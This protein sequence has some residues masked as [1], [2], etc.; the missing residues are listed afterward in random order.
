MMEV[1]PDRL[2]GETAQFDILDNEGNV[3]VESG[4]RISARHTR[5]SR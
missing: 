4:R 3:V 5:C 1:V 2:R